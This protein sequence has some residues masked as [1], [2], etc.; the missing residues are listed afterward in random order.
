MSETINVHG[1]KRDL[2][3]LDRLV[4]ENFERLWSERAGDLGIS[5]RDLALEAKVSRGFV[6]RVLNRER[7]MP[8]SLVKA[9]ARLLQVPEY[10]I[11]PKAAGAALNNV[12]TTS[13]VPVFTRFADLLNFQRDGVIPEGVE[14]LPSYV[15]MKRYQALRETV[16]DLE[17]AEEVAEFRRNLGFCAWFLERNV[18]FAKKGDYLVID[19]DESERGGEKI[20]M[21]SWD[22]ENY[23]LGYIESF[24]PSKELR[25]P[26]SKG[27]SLP[28]D[29]AEYIGYVRAVQFE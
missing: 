16:G 13:N 23:L 17:S 21:W 18:W 14:Y 1:N 9:A 27:G 11:K 28:L 19:L 29:G 3:T 2:S 5:K 24:G 25:V 7:C 12:V 22:Q 4:I 15:V 6:Y 26:E 8:D 10:K 20:T